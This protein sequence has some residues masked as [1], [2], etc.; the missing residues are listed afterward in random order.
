VE[1]SSYTYDRGPLD[2]DTFRPAPY[3][4]AA[5]GWLIIPIADGLTRMIYCGARGFLLAERLRA[6]FAFLVTQSLMTAA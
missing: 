5:S 4:Q 2:R 6:R 3:G 1:A